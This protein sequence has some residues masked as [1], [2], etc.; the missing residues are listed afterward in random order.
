MRQHGRRRRWNVIFGIVKR[1][2]NKE[3]S[4]LKTWWKKIGVKEEER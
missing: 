1:R 3:E 4:T 2:W